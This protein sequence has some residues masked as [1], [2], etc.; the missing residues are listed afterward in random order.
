M[1]FQAPRGTQDILPDQIHRWHHVESTFLDLVARYGYREIR[2]PV[3]EDTELF[4]RTSGDTSEVVNKQMYTFEDKGGRS[5][6]LK[7]EGTAP[8]MRAYI[9]HN[10]AAQSATTR[11]CYISTPVFRYERPQKGR[12]R[13][14]HQLGC[15][16]IGS[17]SPL[18]DAE[19]IEITYKLYEVLGISELLVKV[20]SIGKDATRRA[21][22]EALLDHT[23][24]LLADLE[25]ADREHALRNP[26]RMLDSKDPKFIEALA[27]APKVT[28][29][30]EPESQAHFASVQE[31]LAES[32]IPFEVSPTIVRG[33]DYYND[34]VFELHSTSLGAQS[35]L[36]GG[37]RYDGVIKELGG[38]ETPS[39][40]VG[41]GIERLLIAMESQA[42]VPTP[43]MLEAF[44][45]AATDSARPK[46]RE[47]ARSLRERGVATG[48]DLDGRNVKGQFKAAD[49]SGARYALVLGD[50]ELAGEYLTI[51]DLATQ[52]QWHRAESEVIAAADR[53]LRGVELFAGSHPARSD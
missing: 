2:T 29:Y 15:E 21:Y 53:G 10:L 25:E 22:R 34:T 23:K 13:E 33:L 39:V 36:C 46:V 18:A 12:L 50:D 47:I 24:A 17:A 6:T 11:L 37:G 42:P 4:T 16:L 38:A 31:A 43:P 45:V 26:L 3:F 32:G 49:R 19:I 5:I 8:A 1:R 14:H 48:F 52:D 35:A 41:M 20:N 44:V 9:E 27:D 28:D 51:K 40:G 30:L 7:P